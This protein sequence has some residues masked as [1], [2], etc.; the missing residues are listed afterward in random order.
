MTGL[1]LASGT[2]AKSQSEM[3]LKVW[4]FTKFSSHCFPHPTVASSLLSTYTVSLFLPPRHS[5]WAC[6][7]P[8]DTHNEL[9]S[10]PS[11]PTWPLSS[12]LNT[13][14]S[15]F[16]IPRNPR[17]LVPPLSH[18]LFV[19]PKRKFRANLISLLWCRNL[20]FST[21]SGILNYICNSIIDLN[22]GDCCEYNWIN[23]KSTLKFSW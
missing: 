4:Q 8:L 22:I 1:R 12:S 18:H 15:S 21:S 9:V 17:E 19:K 10:N 16:L 7:F 6:S 3:R 13:H 11:K 14:V 5:Q 2:E 20:L 23:S